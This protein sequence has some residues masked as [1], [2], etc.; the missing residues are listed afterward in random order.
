MSHPEANCIGME[1]RYKRLYTTAQKALRSGYTHF[2]VLKDYAQNISKI[3]SEG[4]IRE[5]YIFFPDPWE[6]PS[7][8]KNRLMQADFLKDLHTITQ[9]GGKV[10]FKTDHREYFDT[11]LELLQKQALWDI[12]FVSYD[13]AQEDIFEK[14]HITEFEGIYRGKNIKINYVELQKI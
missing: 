11:T 8:R 10:Y 12:T 5:T 4:E 14:K 6:K 13:F 1:L 7:E 2:V 9:L 3:F